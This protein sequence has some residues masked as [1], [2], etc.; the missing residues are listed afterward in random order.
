MGEQLSWEHANGI[1]KPLIKYA[2]QGRAMKG[3]RKD[4]EG[5]IAAEFEG[6]EMCQ[7]SAKL[8]LSFLHFCL[9]VEIGRW[10]AC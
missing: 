1:D 10:L 2:Y 4:L 9:F 8:V 6:W 7:K 5:G 3:A